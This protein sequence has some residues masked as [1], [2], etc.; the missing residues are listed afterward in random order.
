M[1]PT[2]KS[3]SPRMSTCCMFCRCQFTKKD[4]NHIGPEQINTNHIGKVQIGSIVSIGS[5]WP[6]GPV[7]QPTQGNSMYAPYYVTTKTPF[8][9]HQKQNSEVGQ[10]PRTHS[11]SRTKF[12]LKEVSL[13]APLSPLVLYSV[14]YYCPNLCRFWGP[15]PQ[16]GRL[17]AL[18]WVLLPR[19]HPHNSI[20]AV[21]W[22]G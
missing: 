12:Y 22:A 14:D 4:K 11:L 10:M 9:P 19:C 1:L 8:L 13:H 15:S 5:L 17:P 20:K 7:P 6:R 16:L 2:T 3:S 18:A 21:T